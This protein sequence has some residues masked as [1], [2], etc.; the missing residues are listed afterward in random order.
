MQSG[1]PR[2]REIS[3]KSISIGM[4]EDSHSVATVVLDTMLAILW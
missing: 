1:Y 2:I 4:T 3:P